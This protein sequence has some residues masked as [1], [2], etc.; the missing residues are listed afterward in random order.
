MDPQTRFALEGL[1][2]QAHINPPKNQYERLRFRLQAFMILKDEYKT[3]IYLDLMEGDGDLDTMRKMPEFENLYTQLLLLKEEVLALSQAEGKGLQQRNEDDEKLLQTNPGMPM[4]MICDRIVTRI[5]RHIQLTQSPIHIAGVIIAK[6]ASWVQIEGRETKYPLIENTIV[7]HIMK[8][9]VEP[10]IS[11]QSQRT[12]GRATIQELIQYFQ[13]I[14]KFGRTG[15]TVK[16]IT[17]AYEKLN[18]GIPDFN[19]ISKKPGAMRKTD[20][21]LELAKAKKRSK[22]GLK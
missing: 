22:R 10:A 14:P 5:G 3:K 9:L 4:L 17:N 19:V 16:G 13:S 21:Y 12:V 15:I 20:S 7:W 11:L 2:L 6:D 8:F 18:R 1:K